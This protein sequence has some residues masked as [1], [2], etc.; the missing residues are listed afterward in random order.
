[1]LAEAAVRNHLLSIK[2]INAADTFIERQQQSIEE[3]SA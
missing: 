2:G 3:D 1:V